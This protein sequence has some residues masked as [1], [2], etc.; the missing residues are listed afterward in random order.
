M[1]ALLVLS[2]FA[3]AAGLLSQPEPPQ[4]PG[5]LPQG[6]F[7]LNSGWRIQPAGKQVPLDTFP[8]A[9]ALSKDGKYLLVL[10]GGYNPPSI[11]VLETA[12][13]AELNRVR[14]ADGWLGLTF[15]PDGKFVYVGGGGK[16][17]VFEFAFNDGKLEPA[18]TF[19]IT[20]ADKRTPKDF[21]GDVAVSPDGRLIYAASLYHDAIHVINPQSGR[22]IETWPTGR[23]PYRILVHP[24]GQSYFVTSWAD[25]TLILH[26][27]TTG[28]KVATLPLGAHPTDMVWR[29]AKKEDREDEDL[30]PFTA[31]LFVAAA[32]TNNVYT[33][34]VTETNELRRLETINVAMT[35]REPVGM[36]PTALAL[37]S[38]RNKL[39]VVC[40][41]ANAVAVADVTEASSL[42]LGFVPTGWYPTAVRSLDDGRLLVLNGRGQHSYPNPDGPSP[43]KVPSVPYNGVRSDEY[44][45]RIQTGSM[46]VIDAFDDEDDLAAYSK[47]VLAN[48]P[49]RDALLDQV[50]APPGSVIPSRPGDPSPIQHVIYVVKEN[51]TYDQVLG[52]LGKGNGD[53]SLALFGEK[54]VPNHRKLALE[55]VLLD[56][57]YVNADVSADG[58][59]WSTSAIAND[60]VQKMWPNSYAGRRKTYDYEGGEPAALPPAGYL[61]N[62][63]MQAG[64]SLR[65]YGWW[66]SNGPRAATGE[67][68]IASVRDPALA[69][70]TNMNYRGFDLDYPDLDRVRIFLADLAAFEKSGD[71]PK[72]ITLRLPNDHTSGTAAGKIAPLSAV[73]D[74]DAALGQIV[75]AVSRSRFWPSTAIFVIEDDAQNGA[76]HVDSHRSPAF[77]I[78]P[79][80]RRGAVDS[81]MYNTTSVL[82]TIELILG[83][84]PMTHFDA[85]ARPMFNAF[86]T[87]PDT[88]PYEAEQPRIALDQRNPASAPM[89]ARSA[90]F[91]FSEA[92]LIDDD[93]MNRILWT[94]LR[95]T[96][97]PPPVRSYFSRTER[98][99]DR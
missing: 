18:R 72:L 80:T 81:T 6:G 66:C 67:K 29:D 41:D 87:E 8:M 35:P 14:V 31:R 96:E 62:N 34:G 79:Y 47:T 84:H 32:N 33:I 27:A 37:S 42:V 4:R 46:S 16:A 9:T 52:D 24:D 58:H 19:E 91:D 1:R 90:Q 77:V 38:D 53:P 88:R 45:A 86:A 95:K 65:N 61:W 64:L 21:I 40:S 23:R 26:N 78:S 69:S 60:Y 70:V 22:V 11:S 7:L 71:M 75:E 43:L 3:A 28:E 2:S 17:S 82:R 92:D 36:T 25:G 59:N 93:E 63:A 99:A 98:T 51:R 74:N 15:S 83:L 5:P 10:N 57:F 56:N 76:D 89:A 44:V 97:P 13:M 94:A 20:P 54:V 30:K 50:P 55:F 68:Q 48:S 85:A 39:F 73:A 12:S 49:Y